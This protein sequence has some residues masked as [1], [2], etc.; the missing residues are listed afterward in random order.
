M[1]LSA[2]LECDLPFMARPTH[3][4]F[5]KG[6]R[7]PAGVAV[8]YLSEGIRTSLG[9]TVH[10]KRLHVAS[11][12]RRVGAEIQRAS[13]R[14]RF[15]CPGGDGHSDDPGLGSDLV[16][17]MSIFLQY[18]GVGG[19]EEAG[20]VKTCFGSRG[21]GGGG[22]RQKRKGWCDFEGDVWRKPRRRSPSR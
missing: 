9:R 1:R 5:V 15:R 14:G 7:Y 2:N 21:R 22:T 12:L 18:S 4:G 8:E 19:L 20:Y 13:V 3:L 6:R 10:R 11:I 17:E 16:V